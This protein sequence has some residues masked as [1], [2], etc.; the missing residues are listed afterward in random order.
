MRLDTNSQNVIVR[1]KNGHNF[2]RLLNDEQIIVTC[3][4]NNFRNGTIVAYVNS[5]LAQPIQ[6]TRYYKR[7]LVSDESSCQSKQ[8]M[9][10]LVNDRSSFVEISCR[11][12]E[13]IYYYDGLNL[14]FTRLYDDSLP[15]IRSGLVLSGPNSIVA[16]YINIETVSCEATKSVN[17]DSFDSIHWFTVDFRHKL[18]TFFAINKIEDNLL[19]YTITFPVQSTLV[20]NNSIYSCCTFK[21]GTMVNCQAFLAFII[22]PKQQIKQQQQQHQIQSK[23]QQNTQSNIKNIIDLFNSFSK[24]PSNRNPKKADTDPNTFSPPPHLLFNQSNLVKSISTTLRPYF[25]SFDGNLRSPSIW[26]SSPKDN[27]VTLRKPSIQSIANLNALFSGKKVINNVTKNKHVAVGMDVSLVSPQTAEIKT[28]TAF[29]INT[30]QTANNDMQLNDN[31][32]SSSNI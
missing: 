5:K 21:N 8:Y 10:Y 6:C 13:S 32:I 22:Y 12:M 15:R 1:G 28:S 17:D 14:V 7:F 24:S 30:N 25:S 27:F 3:A 20:R 18:D 9:A 4:K 26:F 31:T 19:N 11:I 23:T 29:I 2:I 16:H